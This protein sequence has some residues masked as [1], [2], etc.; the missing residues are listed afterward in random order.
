MPVKPTKLRKALESSVLSLFAAQALVR[1]SFFF[2]SGGGK[3]RTKNVCVVCSWYACGSWIL[4]CSFL[5]ILQDFCYTVVLWN[6]VSFRWCV[7]ES[8][9]G[10]V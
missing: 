7:A 4:S 10:H 5:T 8:L 6:S 3:G 9:A 1:L 2:F